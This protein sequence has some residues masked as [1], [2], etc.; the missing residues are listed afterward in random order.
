MQTDTIRVTELAKVNRLELGNGL[1]RGYLNREDQT[2][3]PVD[4][5]DLKVW[6]SGQ[7]LP[8]TPANDDL[9]LVAGTFGTANLYVSAGDCKQATVTRRAR[10]TLTLP[11][12]YVAGR[13]L[14]LRFHAGMLTTISDTSC[15]VDAEAY[16]VG[17]ATLKSG[18]DLVATAAI[19]INSLTFSNKD[20]TLDGSA[21]QPGDQLD[22]RI[23][24]ACVDGAT[25]TAVTPAIGA[26]EP[27]L[28]IRG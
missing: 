12:S 5:G 28:D 1:E 17:R 14:L 23:T 3:F 21:L 8:A 6:D 10:F 15:T 20:F 9:G 16:L 11:P 26:I 19:S 13:D 24:I 4:L 27:L 2:K 25:G 22:I 7:P 18:S